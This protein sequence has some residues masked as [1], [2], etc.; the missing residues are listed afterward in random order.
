MAERAHAR[1]AVLDVPHVFPRL[2]VQRRKIAF[3]I[4]MRGQV[5]ERRGVLVA[6][7][8]VPR[9]EQRRERTVAPDFEQVDAIAFRKSARGV[10]KSRRRVGRRVGRDEHVGI[11]LIGLAEAGDD[12]RHAEGDTLQGQ[13][14]CQL[15][16]RAQREHERFER[17]SMR[18]V[19][20]EDGAAPGG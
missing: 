8:R 19:V 6:P 14:P 16:V 7:D 2:G 4:S 17:L 12:A 3:E 20:I 15:A 11:L 9:C 10:E 1:D 5:D 13:E 18:L